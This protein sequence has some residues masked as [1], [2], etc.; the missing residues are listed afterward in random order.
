MS[1]KL[2]TDCYTGHLLVINTASRRI[3]N[4]SQLCQ[5]SPF[6]NKGLENCRFKAEEWKFVGE[7]NVIEKRALI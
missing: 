7:V 1:D 4:F 3:E 2:Q 5:I 6:S